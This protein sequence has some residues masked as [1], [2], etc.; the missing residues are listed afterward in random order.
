VNNE[1][2]AMLAEP[3]AEGSEV[4]PKNWRE[5]LKY[6]AMSVVVGWHSLAIIVAPAPDNS[7][8]VRSLRSLMQSY[9][10]LFRLDNKWNFFVPPGKF[11]HLRYVVEDASGKQHLFIPTEQPSGSVARYMMWREFKY[12][13]EGVMDVPEVRAAPFAARL[14]TMHASLNPVAISL[15]QVQ[16][17]DFTAQDYLQGYRP[18]DPEF[19]TVDTLANIKC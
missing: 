14:C 16:E 6:L 11:V 2:I 12:L 17:L 10:R 18:L 1:V 7:T 15:L 4:I 3:T 13:Y 8:I 19:V 5:R 9:L